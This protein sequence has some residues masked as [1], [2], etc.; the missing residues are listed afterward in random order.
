MSDGALE[1]EEKMVA[2]PAEYNYTP[3]GLQSESI[4]NEENINFENEE[5]ILLQNRKGVQKKQDTENISDSNEYF[6]KVRAIE[7]LAS[8]W[9]ILQLFNSII[10]YEVS[11]NDH[12]E[13]DGFIEQSLAVSTL[14]SCGLTVSI[15]LR[16]ITHLKWR[17]S[18]LY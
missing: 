7:I 2:Q 14:T 4:D 10:I 15:I 13:H 16:H 11:Y 8:F 6:Q 5:D 9:A 18:K 3:N 17:K 12:G 1:T